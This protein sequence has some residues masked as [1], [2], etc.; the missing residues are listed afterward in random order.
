MRMRT[1][2]SLALDVDWPFQQPP[3]K[4]VQQQPRE[5]K[6]HDLTQ[7]RAAITP[8]PMQLSQQC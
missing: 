7:G 5:A 3:P 6:L 1:P 2:V 8:G 4:R